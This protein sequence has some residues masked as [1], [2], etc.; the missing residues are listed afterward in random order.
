LRCGLR[1]RAAVEALFE[2]VWPRSEEGAAAAA[3]AAARKADAGGHQK[4][5]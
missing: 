4:L 1:A 2:R 5:A 3:R